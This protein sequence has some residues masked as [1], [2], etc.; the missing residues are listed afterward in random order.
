MVKMQIQNAPKTGRVTRSPRHNFQLRHKPFLL[1]PFLLAPVL[2]GETMKNFLLQSR[3]VTKPINNPLVGWWLEYY[4]FYVKHRD[5]VGRDDFTAM[6]LDPDK[7]MSAYVTAADVNYN[8]A[9]ASFNW[10]KM[11]L[12]V[13]T[14]H[15][16]RGE[17]E[18]FATNNVN[19]LPVARMNNDSVLNSLLL[20][21]N[22]VLPTDEPLVVGGDDTIMASEVEAMMRMWEFQKAN[23]L[24]DMTY[25]DFLATYGVTPKAE[26][27][28]RPELLRYLREWQYP[29]NTV[30]PTTGIP[31]SAVSWSV[32]ERADK[33]RYF[34][35]P[36]FVFGVTVAR[37]KVYIGRQAGNVS[38]FLMTAYDW[39][40]AIM[41]DDPWTSLRKQAIAGGP[42]PVITDT[43]GYWIDVKDLFLYGDQFVNF[44]LTASTAD[45][46]VALPTAGGNTNYP[47]L[48]DIDA[49]FTGSDT[50]T[51]YVQQD[52][53]V[54]LSILGA[55]TDTSPNPRRG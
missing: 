51:K 30:D 38:D 54:Q 10:A 20:N 37:P 35:E 24:T 17:D 31:A 16:F 23:K 8:H 9:A 41:R 21:D 7:N 42:F 2:P 47:S 6:M 55:L 43:D 13:V 27:Y 46:S 14:E 48:T 45:N 26:E 39:L 1:Q 52:G 3:A 44:D 11:C 4:V 25:E 50:A 36:G 12:E 32:A 29:S 28:H 18:T 22:L 33:D 40:P 34:R 19:G 5:L 53:A 49:L 15:Y